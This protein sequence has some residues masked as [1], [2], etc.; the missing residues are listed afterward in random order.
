M[1][2]RDRD[3]AIKVLELLQDSKAR[4]RISVDLK[5]AMGRPGAAERVASSVLDT[6]ITTGGRYFVPKERAH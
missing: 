4:D 5:E 1:C 3:V 2:I 6:L